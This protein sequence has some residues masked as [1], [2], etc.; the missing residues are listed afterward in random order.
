MN[1]IKKIARTVEVQ[2]ADNGYTVE[3]TYCDHENIWK[4]VVRIFENLAGVMTF[5]KSLEEFPLND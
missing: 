2:R 4:T 5:L 1:D 3:F